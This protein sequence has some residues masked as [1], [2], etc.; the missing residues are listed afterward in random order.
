MKTICLYSVMSLLAASSAF[1]DAGVQRLASGAAVRDVE[2]S[3]ERDSVVITMGINL[4][5]M[6]VGRN[7][8]VVVAPLF[9]AGEEW[10]WLPAVEVM[11]RTRYLYYERNEES[12]YADQPYSI[13]RRK[14][15]ENQ[16]VNYRVS[17]PY[18]TWMDRAELAAK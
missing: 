11:G 14:K 9:Y 4:S 1:A 13:V 16:Q 5:D 12:L 7:R 15:D 6:E 8:S 10:K 18:E 3:K 2:I 17:L